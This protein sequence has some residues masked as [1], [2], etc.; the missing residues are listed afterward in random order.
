MCQ[1]IKLKPSRLMDNFDAMWGANNHIY[2]QFNSNIFAKCKVA[3]GYK[4]SKVECNINLRRKLY[5][6]VYNVIF[7]CYMH[8]SYVTIF[9]VVAITWHILEENNK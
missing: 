4:F 2:F 8:S 3:L 7:L 1:I 5:L 9:L 6:A